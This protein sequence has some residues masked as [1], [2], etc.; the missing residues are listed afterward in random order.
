MITA[1]ALQNVTKKHIDNVLQ[2]VSILFHAF[3]PHPPF[4]LSHLY[5]GYNL[6]LLKFQHADST[7]FH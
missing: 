4:F 5:K 7:V 3:S 2:T 6:K 1:D